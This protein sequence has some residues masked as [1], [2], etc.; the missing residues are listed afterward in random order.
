MKGAASLVM[1]IEPIVSRSILAVLLRKPNDTSIASLSI[2]SGI[3]RSSCPPVPED[4]ACSECVEPE[5][6]SL[7]A[8]SKILAEIEQKPHLD[9]ESNP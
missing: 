2:R 1:R 9:V 8:D 5:K 6:L 4:D 3:S 7:V